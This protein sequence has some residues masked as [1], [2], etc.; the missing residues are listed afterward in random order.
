MFCLHI[1]LYIKCISGDQKRVSDPCS[2]SYSYTYDI[3][4]WVLGIE[5]WECKK[6][7]SKYEFRLFEAQL[8]SEINQVLRIYSVF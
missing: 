6:T 2:G 5:S 8:L 7:A 1:Y 4:T 3:F